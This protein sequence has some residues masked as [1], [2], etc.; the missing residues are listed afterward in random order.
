MGFADR[1]VQVERNKYM[2]CNGILMLKNLQ[3]EIRR[4]TEGWKGDKI[5]Q[6]LEAGNKLGWDWICGFICGFGSKSCDEVEKH[7]LTCKLNPNPGTAHEPAPVH[8]T[9]EGI[10]LERG[11]TARGTQQEQSSG[12]DE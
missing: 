2:E 3:N 5:Q 7:E 12:R 6:A 8:G 10:R 11:G 1:L 9:P 4:M